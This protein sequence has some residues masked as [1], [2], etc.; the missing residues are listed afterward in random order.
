MILPKNGLTVQTGC[1]RARQIRMG[2]SPYG[3]QKAMRQS[4]QMHTHHAMRR[5]E[6]VRRLPPPQLPN[7][8]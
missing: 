2:I 3:R 4:V 7:N 8:G 5:V 1:L 6:S